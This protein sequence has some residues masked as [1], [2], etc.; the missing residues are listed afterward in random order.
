MLRYSYFEENIHS[1]IKQYLIKISAYYL[2]F[3]IENLNAF[4]RVPGGLD[5]NGKNKVIL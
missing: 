1:T 3:Q 5:F 2:W 4:L